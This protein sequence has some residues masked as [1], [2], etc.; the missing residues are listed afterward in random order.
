MRH[1]RRVMESIISYAKTKGWVLEH[2]WRN[3]QR[4]LVN[5]QMSRVFPVGGFPVLGPAPICRASPACLPLPADGSSTPRRRATLRSARRVPGPSIKYRSQA[6]QVAAASGFSP[7][8]TSLCT[9]LASAEKCPPGRW[10][11]RDL[12]RTHGG[13]TC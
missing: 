13:N 3:C 1:P 2:R 12:G 11:P 6:A 7:L 8:L 10:L 4:K 5:M 9:Q